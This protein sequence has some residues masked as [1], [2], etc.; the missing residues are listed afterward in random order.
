MPLR[1]D[2]NYPTKRQKIT[3]FSLYTMTVFL[4]G[5][6]LGL[7]VNLNKPAST[8]Q[9]QRVKQAEV[10]QT[11]APACLFGQAAL[12][13]NI[14]YPPN[15]NL[16]LIPRQSG[17]LLNKNYTVEFLIK[18]LS[19]KNYIN[20]TLFSNGNRLN[21]FI[22]SGQSGKENK[23]ALITGD[24][25]NVKSLV[26]PEI[27]LNEWH[28]IAVSFN[29]TGRNIGTIGL[30]VDGNTITSAGMPFA[31]DLF[32]LEMGESYFDG[33]IDEIRIL[34]KLVYSLDEPTYLN[35]LTYQIPP[36]P[37]INN[38]STYLLLHLDGNPNDS[39]SFGN[40]AQLQG[41][42]P[43]IRSY[44]RC[45]LPIPTP[46]MIPTPTVAPS[47]KRV[48]VTSQHYNGNLGGLDGADAI[49]Q[50]TAD[51]KGLGGVWK[52]WLSDYHTSV[53]DRLNHHT[54]SYVLLDGRNIANSWDDLTDGISND[55][56][57]LSENNTPIDEQ[58]VWTQTNTDGSSG[59]RN[60]CQN[61]TNGADNY[62]GDGGNT[63][64][65]SCSYDV[66]VTWT[67]HYGGV[68]NAL[69]HLYCFEQ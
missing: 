24:G 50:T 4:F 17:F 40:N 62:S 42:I 49:C 3:L 25:N 22:E 37:F 65:R 61:W 27:T 55:Y 56:I 53:K 7:L 11:E 15:K 23:V 13:E 54:G 67:T 39:S 57:N 6:L 51:N 5:T 59:Q 46:T 34:D 64:L 10:Y 33:V 38:P 43:F 32:V 66:C 31:D 44:Y 21:V 2:K 19:R 41:D 63:T 28:H 52:A 69:G 26:G 1:V 16:I 8:P 29:K 35:K 30:H 58:L 60:S 18:Q 45:I 48:F 20:P 12:V 14:E 36:R 9:T 68:C 47:Y